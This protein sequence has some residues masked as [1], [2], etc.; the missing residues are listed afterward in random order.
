MGCL[1]GSYLANGYEDLWLLDMW[2]EHVVKIEAD[3]VTL[4][5]PTGEFL[6][7]PRATML[8]S[9]IGPADLIIVAVKSN[10]TAEAA[11]VAEYFLKPDSVV[12]TLQN[13][14]GNIE[15]LAEVVGDER[16]LVGMTLMGAKILEPGLVVHGGLRETR[17]ASWTKNDDCR[18]DKIVKM[19][20]KAGLPTVVESNVHSLLWSKLSI[21]AGINAVTALTGL[22]NEAFINSSDAVRLARM[23]VGEVV[24]VATVA[25]IPLLYPNCAEEMMAYAE[26][27]R[28]QSSPMLD[29]F[30]HGRKMEVEAINGSVVNLGKMFGVPTPVNETLLLALKTREQAAKLK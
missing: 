26:A 6:A 10:D 27:M 2:Q 15:Q 4:L 22:N 21:H 24:A 9:N 17:I 28:E 1:Y 14:L 20:N 16:L 25:G 19:F 5:S 29:D 11:L 8:A 18:V 13:G 30:L 3:G 7:R 23:A 12:L